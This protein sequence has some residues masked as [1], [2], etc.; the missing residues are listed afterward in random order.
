MSEVS[1]DLLS[2]STAYVALPPEKR[3][4]FRGRLRERGI[5][6]ARLPIVPFPGAE[7][8]FPLSHAQERLWFLWRLD[9]ASAAYN[10]TGAVRLRGPLDV[11][12]LRAALDRVVQAHESL[13]QR[14]EEVDGVPYQSAGPLDYGWQTLTLAQADAAAGALDALLAE[15]SAAPFDLERG[16]LLRVALI[17]LAPDHHVL[18]VA[19]HH[20][21]SDGLSIGVLV[22]DLGAAYA[23][24]TGAAAE[25][26]AGGGRAAPAGVQYGDYAQ[27]QREWL[28]DGALA[29]QLDYWRGRLGTDHPVLELPRTRTRAGL[30]SGA[31]GRV[32]RVLPPALHAALLRVSN[33]ADATPFMTLL[34]AYVLLLAR[35]SGQRDIRVGVPAAGRD[36]PEVAR[37]IGFFVNTLVIRSELDA[38]PTF[39]ALLAQV[40]ERVLEAQAHADLP[41]T[42]L[43]EALQPQRSFGNTPLFQAMFNY[44]GRDDDTIRLP[45]LDATHYEIPVQ[46]ARFDLVLDARERANG[47]ELAFTYAEDLFDA[48]TL[49]AMLDY[50]VALLDAALDAPQR[51][52][53]ALAGAAPAPAPASVKPYRSVPARFAASAARHAASL[54]VHCEGQRATYAQLDRH[55]ER[56]AQ[57]LAAAGVRPDARV[58]IC[59]TR[60]LGMVAALLG[61][62]RSPGAFVPLDP[63]YPAERLAMMMDDAGVEVVLTDAAARRQCGAL[64]AGRSAIDV[65]ALEHGG[66]DARPAAGAGRHEP[67]PDQLAYVIYTSGSTGRPKGV[68]ISHGALAAHLDDFITAHGIGADDTQLQSSTINFDVALHELLPALLQ[69]G[70][71]EMRGAEPWDIDTTSRHLIEARVTFSRLPTAY[72][73]QWLRTPPPPQALAALRQITVGGEGLPGDALAQWQRGPLGRIGLANLYGPTETTVACLYR[74]TTPEDAAQPI[75]SIGVPYA[76]RTARVLDR[77]G[78]EAPVGALGELCIGGHTL[79]RGYLDRPA[80]TAERFVP[81]PFGA[82]GARLY[83]TGDLCRRR[84]DGAIDFLG[85]LDQQIKLRGF[86]IEPGEIE[87]ALRRQPGVA[88]AVVVLATERGA[89]RL[90]GYVVGAAG[91]TLDG[92]QLQR[93]L[94]QQLPAHMV[95][96]ALAVLD[97]MPLMHNGK[98]DRAALPAVEAAPAD[99]PRAAPRNEAERALLAWWGA[100]LNRD[101]LGIDDDF[102]AAG[103]DSILSLQLIAKARAQGWLITPRQVFEQPTV[104]RLAAVMRPLETAE[105][106]AELHGPL[107]LTPIQ[108]WFHARYPDGQPHWNQSVLLRVRG[109][110]DAAAFERALGAVIARHDALRLCFERDPADGAWRQRVLAEAPPLRL[111]SVDLREAGARWP[112]ALADGAER[113]QCAL[114][115]AA[116]RLVHAV[117]WRTPDLA[118]GSPDGRLLLVIHHLAVDGVSWRILL[119][120]L[121]SAYAAASAGRAIALEAALPW[122]VWAAAQREA[123]TPA[124]LAAALPAWRAALA[125]AAV[126]LEAPAGSVATSDVV[127]WKLEPEAT[128]ALRRA[129]P[130]AYRLGVDELLL[131]ALARAAAATFG[132][133]G[134]L[135]AL[136]GHGRDIHERHELDP[137]RTVGWFTTRYPAWLPAPADDAAALIEAKARLRALPDGGA[138]WGWLQ[139][140]G[141]PAAQAALAALPAPRISFNYLGQFDGSLADDGPFGF[142]TEASGAQQPADEALVYAVDV[143]GMIVD[144]RLSLSWRFDPARVSPE[145]QHALVAGFGREL[146]RFVAHCEQAVPRATAADFPRAALDEAGF[147]A[148]GL[149]GV[150][151]EDLYP[152]TPLQQGLLFHSLLEPGAY[153]N[154][155]RLTLRGEVDVDAMRRAWQT[156]I[157]RHPVL[158]TRFVRAHGGTMLQAV[159]A[160]VPLPFELHDWRDRADYEAA[161]ASWFEAEAPKR[162]D[163]DAAP[164]MHVSLFRRPD[165]AHDLAWINHHALSDGWSQSQLLGELTRAYLAARAGREAA[166]DAVVPF[167]RYT[168]WL[169]AQP[170]TGDWWRAQ[171]AR[172]DQPALLLDAVAAPAAP[173]AARPAGCGGDT[174]RHR[175]ASLGAALSA[176][177]AD[178]ARR[179]GVTL[180]TL[181]QA[182]WALVLARHGDRR[183]AAFGVTVAGRPA[184][185]AG[186]AQIQGVFINS[187]PLWVDVPADAPLQDWLLALQHRNVELRQVE[188]TPLTSIQQWAGA[189]AGTLFDSL[190]VFENYPIDPALKDGSLGLTVEASVSFER[191]H[192]PLTLGVLPGERI[193]L[194]WSWDASRLD[195]AALD[196]L[197]AAYEAMLAQLAR[198][199]LTTLAALRAAVPADGPAGLAGAAVAVPHPYR[200][201]TARFEAAVRMRGDALALRC[202]D[203]RLGYAALDRAANRIARRLAD[204]GVRPGAP[205]GVCLERSPALIA[206]LF[207]VLQAGGAY[208]PLDPAY[209]RER[210][211]DMCDDA[212]IAIVLTDAATAAGH[213]D[214][215]AAAGRSALDAAEA[216]EAGAAGAVAARPACAEPH[217]EQPAY[218]I[219]TS[220]STGRPKGVAI[221]HGALS[222]HLDDFIADHGLRADDHVLQFSTVN[223]DASVEQIFAPLALGASLEMRGPALWSADE[224]DR[225]LAERAVTFAYLPTGYWRQ[226][227][228][229]ARA[230]PGL[231]LRRMLIGGE[232]LPGTAVAQWFDSP[233]RE[234]P[235]FNTY[236]PTEI[237]VTSSVQRVE[238]AQAGCLA[239][240]IGRPSV[241]RVYRILDRDGQP[242]PAHGVGELCIG[243]TTLAHGYAGQPALSAERFV[244]DPCGA[245]GARL[246]RTGDRCRWLPDGGVAFL[247]RLDEQVKVRGFRIEPGEIE[248]ALLARPEVAEAVA[249]VQGDGDARRVVAHV[250]AAAGAAPDAAV[251]RAALAER[252]P[253]YLVPAAIGV[254]DALP[255]LPNGKLD[256]RA[257][258][259]L[260]ADPAAGYVAPATPLETTV[261]EIWQAVLGVE[262]IGARDDF[263][264]L[265]GHSLLALQV[266]ARLQRALGREVPLRAL[267][268]HPQLAA[269]AAWLEAGAAPGAR[270]LPPVRASGRREAPPT[271]GQTRLW[272]LWRLAPD[273]PAYHLSLAVR[274]DGPLDA[275]RLRAA[276]DAVVARHQMLHS[277]FD[278]RDGA[279]WLVVDDSLRAGWDAAGFASADDA[280]CLAWLRE[281]GAQPFDLLRGPLLRARLAQVGPQAHLFQLTLHHIATDGWSMS[282]LIDELAAAYEAALA[283]DASAYAPALPVQYV[284]YALWQHAS[285][286]AA[287][288]DAQLDYWRA[289]L[290]DEQPV[291]ELPAD[292][293]RPAVRDGRGA[294]VGLELD[295]ALADA[296][297]TY[298]RRHDATLFMTLL[299]AF[300]ALL[301]RYGGQRDVR[302]GIALGGRERIEIEPL[303]GFFVNTA[304]IR[305]ELSGALPFEALLAQVRQRVLDAQANQDVP[306]A[307]LVDAL[308]PVRAASHTPLFQAMFNYDVR[309]GASE[310]RIGEALRLRPFGAARTAAQFDLTLGVTVGERIGLSFGYATDLFERDTVERLLDDYRGLLAQIAGGAADAGP[311]PRLRE[312]RLAARAVAGRG[313]FGSQPFVAVHERIAAQ[314]RRS[315]DAVAVRCDGVVHSY[316]ELDA[317]AA[318]LARQLLASGIGA[319]ARVGVCTA[320]SGAM[321]VAV[322]AALKAGAAYV[323]LDPA[324]PDAHLAGMIEDAGLACTLA[325]VAGRARLGALG[326]PAGAHRLVDLDEAGAPH[327]AAAACEAGEAGEAELPAVDPAQLAYVIYTS[328]STGRPKGVGVTHGALARFLDSLRARLAPTPDD[329]WLAVTT[330]SFD[331]AALELYLPLAAGA[332][333]ELATRETVVDGTKLAALAEAS[334][335]TLM[336]ATPMGW[337]LLLDGGWQGRRGRF[338]ALCGGEALPPDLADALLARGVALWNLYGP[339]ETTIWSSAARLEPGAPITLGAPLEHTTLQVLDE[340]GQ[341]VPDNGVGELC[342]GG[343][344]LARGYLGRAGQTAERFVPDPHGAPGARLYRTGDLCR[345]RRD[346]RLDYLGRADQ[347]VKLR[348]FRIELGATEAA[349]RA[350]DGVRH[351]A[352]RIVG[353]GSARRLVAY[354]TGEADPAGLRARLA[355]QLPMQQVPA[356]VVRL[357]A[358]PLTSNGKLNRNA[359]PEVAVQDDERYVAPQ[360]PTERHVCETWAEVLG[361]ARAG[362]DDD[363]FVLGGHSLAAVRVAARLGERLGRRVELAL[364]FSHPRAADL[365]ARLDG[366]AAGA[367][368]GGGS[369]DAM[370]GLL[371]S[372]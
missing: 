169:A 343:A 33:A 74:A 108:A 249:V 111:V 165:G 280:A 174:Y 69:G 227:V 256:R 68:A 89:A 293:P 147:D 22:N 287:A 172:V 148:L 143:N 371:D 20:I 329:V 122:S 234:V 81:D 344:N 217:P 110:L 322:L 313:G 153:L 182:A 57:A 295:R 41:F 231:A 351:A 51:P 289:T 233:L 358:L 367:G 132:G 270:V 310:R 150:A 276:L 368:E 261:A 237:A 283:G 127:D 267:F 39:A 29:R 96:A 7:R 58:G 214:W 372:L 311:A 350:L 145:R 273:N 337:R 6:A 179:R 312:L 250:V 136:E 133:D 370:Q 365:A 208:V 55:A 94:A 309:Q 304:V 52:L 156:V 151:L 357:E 27:W 59:M 291:L 104:A 26:P 176:A 235:L 178:S 348:G 349:L 171:L 126:P 170:D 32:A 1:N 210:L 230:R 275:A 326:A 242:V 222:R 67:H 274:I 3:A 23:A 85:R 46:T 54:A 62:L 118:D 78:N 229:Q 31:G 35:Y 218:L 50:F 299:A 236:G 49:G 191:T 119:A 338:T 297:Q 160:A 40:R 116:G 292:R 301:H 149:A 184:E 36:R 331:I 37:T 187:L 303:I 141:D 316:R 325:D 369:L 346:G 155:K 330:L 17:A 90:V 361:I 88:E 120:D 86:R 324:Y 159:Q 258:P 353:E 98:V 48:A 354:V 288:L 16:P 121:A 103:G 221:S 294:Q 73:Q 154:R 189:Q 180:N 140:Y 42:K 216:I 243:G 124:R 268:D 60:S 28:D 211:R 138:S 183:Q 45:G 334:G 77:D 25:V 317:R 225:V 320:R 125:G 213:A 128:D 228:R 131:A 307:R 319:E 335:A 173:A 300:H 4:V 56:V 232:A 190:L 278:E 129:A 123:A 255:T 259:R 117:A 336:Q 92:A 19:L 279:P 24:C 207:G 202:G 248:A 362:L 53:A 212:G 137:S 198:P 34:A 201:V 142:A 91:T 251:L 246:Y 195:A 277:R 314:A 30:R 87:A 65:D 164:L 194:E 71:I 205:V 241:S 161:F 226:W 363:F 333:I 260:E 12:A 10:V 340:S 252:L 64:F 79:A 240:P 139:A 332:T 323:P 8:R 47:F 285:L 296:L 206:A 347:Q 175:A 5:D 82:P 14:F 101:D 257:L 199:E 18:H 83:R 238:P 284:D 318:R 99:G 305:A 245:P 144:G 298:A 306:F 200:P 11:A 203:A 188:H 220:G 342:I 44:L 224:L 321:L 102:F 185:L 192:Y 97:R 93:V 115:P 167:S 339:T 95:P 271:H 80:Q 63:A 166:L 2:I 106:A 13:R 38:A 130:R 105:T 186:A 302:I 72:W 263:F 247:G 75:V 282:L 315:P 100:V 223:F 162:I 197:A 266:A 219:Y 328:G 15:R 109:R 356:Q 107:P 70:S 163:L 177:L 61:T 157:A 366:E 134:A 135:V 286:D 355:E 264:A 43:V 272:F 253:A 308:Q 168:D 193:G 215:I 360:T 341:P 239:A 327:A 345:V 112:A 244:P 254:L 265:G 290:G 158:R 359:L 114:D 76:S 152:A 66:A 21:V 364:L 84:A 113:A 269:L 9:P 281:G 209:P 204:A 146:A 262:R 352:C 196:A 181:I